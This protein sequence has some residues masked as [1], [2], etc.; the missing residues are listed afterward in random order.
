MSRIPFQFL[1]GYADGHVAGNWAGF[2]AWQ[3]KN[4]IRS[5]L[6]VSRLPFVLLYLSFERGR[7]LTL[8]NETA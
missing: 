6:I 3:R 2:S 1:T 5:A 7:L 8:P 4:P